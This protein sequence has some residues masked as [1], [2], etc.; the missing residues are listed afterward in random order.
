MSK[1]SGENCKDSEYLLHTAVD[2]LYSSLL[3]ANDALVDIFFSKLKVSSKP[4]NTID[5]LIFAFLL[6]DLVICMGAD[7]IFIWLISGY[8]DL[9]MNIFLEIPRKYVLY[10]N[11]QC[12]NYTAEYRVAFLAYL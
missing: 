9:I 12:E 11:T 7:I 3:G 1:V 8:Q 6:A 2:S 5:C 10:L 4:S